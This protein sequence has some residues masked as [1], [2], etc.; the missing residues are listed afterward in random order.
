MMPLQPRR[1]TRGSR[2]GFT[3]LEILVAVLILALVLALL[4]GGVRAVMGFTK[5]TVDR[6]TVHTLQMAVATFKKEFGFLPPLV[7]D[8]DESAGQPRLRY[9][10]HAGLPVWTENVAPPPQSTGPVTRKIAIYGEDSTWST[11]WQDDF[12]QAEL[13]SNPN[14]P[15]FDYRFS[16]QTLAYYLAGGLSTSWVNNPMWTPAEPIDGVIGPGFLAPFQDGRFQLPSSFALDPA[17][18][19]AIRLPRKY[20]PLVN[21]GGSAPKLVAPASGS[22]GP[23][24]DERM[25]QL[26]DRSN[27]PIRYYRWKHRAQP[28][29]NPPNPYY[30]LCLP[31]LVGR[32]PVSTGLPTPEDRD[33]SRN[34]AL[35]SATY[36]IVAAGPNGV[37]GDEEDL[38]AMC[39]K[40]GVGMA[41]TPDKEFQ[42]RLQAEKDNIVEVGE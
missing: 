12:V 17:S 27:V 34:I 16:E 20:E 25:V 38:A 19:A 4:I 10:P 8:R 6:Q 9:G 35:R 40:M 37:F 32:D 23:G 22:A 2:R 36:A 33:V 21:I 24:N 42:V 15:F 30:D 14:N 3:L 7:R 18:R 31:R 39:R 13:S 41:T 11:T 5:S 29:S 1:G 26:R 28:T